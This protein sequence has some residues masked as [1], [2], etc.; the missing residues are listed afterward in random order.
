MATEGCHL[1]RIRW[2]NVIMLYCRITVQLELTMH[3]AV[4]RQPCAVLDRV[5]EILDSA[6]R[7]KFQRNGVAA[8]G[9]D[10]DL[11]VLTAHI[12]MVIIML[13]LCDCEQRSHGG[14]DA[15][16]ARPNDNDYNDQARRA[17]DDD[18]YAAH[19]DTTGNAASNNLAAAI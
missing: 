2:L 1:K 5:N 9:S 19:R 6:E 10:K 14:G 8:Q 18:Y 15:S 17:A 13:F 7:V 12:D 3:K 16:T 11:K 4:H